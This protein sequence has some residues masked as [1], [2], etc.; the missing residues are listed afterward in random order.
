MYYLYGAYCHRVPRAILYN[1]E[2]RVELAIIAKHCEPLLDHV[3]TM[4]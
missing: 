2:L 3:H 4:T 1:K